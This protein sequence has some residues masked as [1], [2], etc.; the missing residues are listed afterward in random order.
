MIGPLSRV[1]NAQKAD[2]NDEGINKCEEKQT[3]SQRANPNSLN[4]NKD[5]TVAVESQGSL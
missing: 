1:P 3:S 2:S 5:F 4:L